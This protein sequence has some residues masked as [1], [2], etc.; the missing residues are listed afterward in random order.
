VREETSVVVVTVDRLWRPERYLFVVLRLRT[1]D[2]A[3]VWLESPSFQSRDASAIL[4]DCSGSCGTTSYLR[5]CSVR[6]SA[7][8][9]NLCVT[10]NLDPVT[11]FQ[12][13]RQLTL[14]SP[15]PRHPALVNIRSPQQPKSKTHK[16]TALLRG[17]NNNPTL[18]ASLF[19][20][21]RSNIQYSHRFP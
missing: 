8:E 10:I 11:I 5:I 17:H 20:E 9:P 6:T 2:V 21:V 19:N 15:S 7:V 12:P 16:P 18:S 14:P 1:D 13:K 3:G 4:Q